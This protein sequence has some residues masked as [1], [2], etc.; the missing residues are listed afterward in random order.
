MCNYVD[1]CAN[2]Q[3]EDLKDR[4]V[5]LIFT[6]CNY[7][8]FLEKPC[9]NYQSK[10]YKLSMALHSFVQYVSHTIDLLYIQIDK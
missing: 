7:K 6:K 8:G 5:F 9:F 4:K 3:I 10:S 1:L 2:Q